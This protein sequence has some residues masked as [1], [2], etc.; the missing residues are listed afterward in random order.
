MPTI[1]TGQDGRNNYTI[2][3]GRSRMIIIF[4]SEI[5]RGAF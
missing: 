5:T 4:L 3:T 1:D 2:I